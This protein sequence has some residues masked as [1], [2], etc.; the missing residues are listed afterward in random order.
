[1]NPIVSE[2]IGSI[3]RQLL[4]VLAGY[5]VSKGV[6]TTAQAT[7]YVAAAVAGLLALGWSLYQK[8]RARQKLVVALSAASMT[9]A[10]VESKVRA[11]DVP[12]M[13]ASKHAVPKKVAAVLLVCS[14][15]LLNACGAQ[16]HI[17]VQVDAAFATAVFAAS[18]AAMEACKTMV[19]TPEQCAVGGSVNRN[20]QQA[21]LD[22]KAVTT[23]LQDSK[24][25]TVPKNLPDL[26]VSL[27]NLQKIVGDLAPTIPTKND[28]ATK[29]IAAINQAIAV[30]KAYTGATS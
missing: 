22:V 20:A 19:F 5:F 25:S 17:A 8:Y 1:M 10:G 23:A 2:A 24:D 30:L 18:D 11:G 16:R 14:G 7:D 12:N 9:E 4:A 21:L 27:T 13:T 15:L 6:W 28:L 29:I 26:L 3:L